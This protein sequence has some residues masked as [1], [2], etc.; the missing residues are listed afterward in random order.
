MLLLWTTQQNERANVLS[1]VPPWR[2][3]SNFNPMEN[4]YPVNVLNFLTSIKFFTKRP[5][6]NWYFVPY[7]MKHCTKASHHFFA[8]QI[9]VQNAHKFDNFLSLFWHQTTVIMA[10]L[11][12]SMKR[13][14]SSYFASSSCRQ[15][16]LQNRPPIPL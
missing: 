2:G 3:S 16:W 6:I 10:T 4:N 14:R 7:Q 1:S 9:S 11:P 15:C 8:Y 12:S 13:K 5:R